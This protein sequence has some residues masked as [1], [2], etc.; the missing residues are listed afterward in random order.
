MRTLDLRNAFGGRV[1]PGAQPLFGPLERIRLR[2]DC[3]VRCAQIGEFRIARRKRRAQF[4]HL[5]PQQFDAQLGVGARGVGRVD[6][7][8]RAGFE[9]HHIV[10]LGGHGRLPQRAHLLRD[11]DGGAGHRE[12]G[13]SRAHDFGLYRV[14]YPRKGCR[15][16]RA[17]P[18]AE[19]PYRHD[20]AEA[21]AGGRLSIACLGEHRQHG[22]TDLFRGNG[23]RTGHAGLLAGKR[24]TSARLFHTYITL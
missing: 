11:F 13:E 3:S 2:G 16:A 12:V 15:I 9:A 7:L 20:L 19:F 4:S 1:E 18:R 21:F 22:G 10:Q 6:R 23:G 5:L 17:E 14:Q 24:I 8:L